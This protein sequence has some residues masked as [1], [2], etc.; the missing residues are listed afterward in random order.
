MTPASLMARLRAMTQRSLYAGGGDAAPGAGDLPVNA[1]P[2]TPANQARQ[3]ALQR[4]QIGLFGIAA[5]VLLVGL[6][7]IIGSQ[8]D[9]TEEAAVPEAAPTT[10]PTATPTQANPLA[11][12]GVVPDIAAE[13]S[14]TPVAPL[15]LPAP[16]T[17]PG[18]DA[19]AP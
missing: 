9:I 8:A 6:A 10:E 7:S 2:A 11:D 1:Q 17:A 3:E 4:L 14:P 5:M 13:P 12:A 15:D 16:D 19:P 18:N